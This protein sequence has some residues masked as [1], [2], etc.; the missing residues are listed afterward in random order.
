MAG[1]ELA[2][3]NDSLQRGDL[4][5][6]AAAAEQ[7]VALQDADDIDW[8]FTLADKFWTRGDQFGTDLMEASG[9]DPRNDK[10]AATLKTK[11]GS[12]LIAQ[13]K[14][15][16]HTLVGVI[17]ETAG[18]KW[19]FYINEHTYESQK[20][21]W[22][23]TASCLSIYDILYYLIIW[24]SWWLPLQAQPFSH[25]IF[26]G[27]LVTVIE[28][29]ITECALR[30]QL[31]IWEF[32]NN[33]LSLNP[34]VRA[35]FGTI[36]QTIENDELSPAAFVEM[37]KT[38]LYVVRTNPFLDTSPLVARTVRMESC[39]TVIRDLTKAYGVCVDVTLWEPGDPQPDKWA[40]LTKP[41]YVVTVKDRSQ[42]EGPTG[43]VLD[44]VLRTTV[45][46][47]GSLGDIFAPIIQEVRSMPGVYT[48]PLLGVNF[49]APYTILVAA[50]EGDKSPVLSC[51]VVDH[52][53][54]AWQIIIGGKS[55]KWL[56]D[57]INA[58]LSW[59][60]DSLMIVIGFTGVPS[61]LL[62]GFMNDAFF[63]FQLI[64]HYGRRDD[65]GPMH[66]NL[67]V[68]IPTNA[69]PYNIEAVFSFL[70]ALHDTR[71]YTSAQATVLNAPFGPYALGRDFQRGG[72]MSLVYPVPGGGWEMF[73]DYVED[74]PWRVAQKER[75]VMAMIGDGKAEEASIA[76]HQRIITGL[77]EV[78]NVA[79][80]APRS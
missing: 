71:G 9:N 47:G 21:Q 58:T 12:E 19:A 5:A 1:T 29:M 51:K 28:N 41:T 61:N 39:G 65:M 52:T 70:T 33:A 74:T 40:N 16:R 14:E 80:L 37:L 78:F 69:P 30:I 38:P 53:P 34:D 8:T 64:Q 11:G 25:A 45:D 7:I 46:L 54:K 79:T 48:A 75:H 68:M 42:I 22:T 44:S 35:W 17:V 31:G 57:L 62:D 73:T 43:T 60:I 26:V 63:A 59:L 20:A 36:L 15:C 13:M 55:P 32:V 49:R 67:E 77:Q 6:Q 27:P 3:L 50:E 24:P 23:S 56:N 2:R 66:P 72:L 4:A 76:K 18:V 10:A